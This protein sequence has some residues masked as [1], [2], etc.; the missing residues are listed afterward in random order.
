MPG[1][2]HHE[3]TEQTKA[4]V[5]ALVSFGVTREEIARYLEISEDTLLR[6]YR[7]EIEN[8]QL[9][10]NAQVAAK[11]FKKAT[12]NEDLSAI[13]FWLKTRARWRTADKDDDRKKDSIIEALLEK[14]VQ[15]K[16]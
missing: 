13:I 2:P 5:S 10:A 3:A 4:K 6:H 16:K 8:S 12:K 15:E 9:D 7:Y 11:L 14:L 1:A